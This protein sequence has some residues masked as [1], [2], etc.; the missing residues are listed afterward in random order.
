M[1][2][3]SSNTKLTREEESALYAASDSFR[4]QDFLGFDYVKAH[5]NWQK[6]NAELEQIRL[7]PY[8]DL[9]FKHL[10]NTIDFR[11]CCAELMEKITTATDRSDLCVPIWEF[12]NYNMPYGY[13]NNVESY[14]HV[15][16][17]RAGVKDAVQAEAIN[18]RGFRGLVGATCVDDWYGDVDFTHPLVEIDRIFRKTD[19]KERLALHFGGIYLTVSLR[20]HYETE[21][22]DGEVYYPIRSEVM[23]NYYPRGI[24]EFKRKELGRAALKYKDYV[25][26]VRRQ[27]T[28]VLEDGSESIL[29]RLTQLGEEGRI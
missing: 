15:Q 23:L 29:R 10:T 5:D 22:I 8:N 26:R 17:A 18:S 28:L 21:T 3:S 20:Q 11:R 6:R 16:A 7:Q 19:L 4:M 24:P 2:S 9:L 27:D 1:A 25:S 12:K 14:A 13:R